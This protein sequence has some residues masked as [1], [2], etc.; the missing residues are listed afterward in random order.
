M[1]GWSS[2]KAPSETLSQAFDRGAWKVEDTVFLFMHVISKRYLQVCRYMLLPPCL[3][4]TSPSGRK[5]HNVIQVP[6]R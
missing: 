3:S 1:I 2:P 5:P 4:K 6:F